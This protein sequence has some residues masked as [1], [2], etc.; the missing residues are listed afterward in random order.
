MFLLIR[1]LYI[2][3]SI[4]SSP[5]K[6]QRATILALVLC[7]VLI[8]YTALNFNFTGPAV[9]SDEIGYLTKAALMAGYVTD[10]A[11]SWQAGYSMFIFPAFALFNDPA[12][13]WRAVVFINSVL[14]VGSLGL[15]YFLLKGIFPDKSFWWIIASI[16]FCSIYPSW[17]IMAG[18][19]FGTPAFLFIFTLSSLVIAK[20]S[21]K[22]YALIALAGF[23]VGFL[24]WI[25]PIGLAVLMAAIISFIFR[26]KS[27]LVGYRSLVIFCIFAFTMV[28]FYY[29]ILHPT[30]SYLVVPEGY[31]NNQHYSEVGRD[32]NILD[33]KLWI[34]IIVT[35][36]SQLSYL[37]VSTF[38]IVMFAIV[39]MY[40]ETI[41]N[42]VKKKSKSN[43][44]PVYV[45]IVFSLVGVILMG[46]VMF[47]MTGENILRP[48]HRI[49]GRY[50]EMVLLPVMGIGLLSVWKLRYSFY[51]AGLLLLSGLA[52]SFYVTHSNTSDGINYVNIAAFWPYM[53]V[54][55]INYLYWFALGAVAVVAAALLGKKYFLFLVIPLFFVIAGD[56]FKYHSSLLNDPMQ[57]KKSP[58]VDFVR[59][60]IKNDCIG[61]DPDDLDVNMFKELRMRQY[62]YYLYDYSPQRM[63]F[64]NWLES[65]CGIYLTFDDSFVK[66]NKSYVIAK[67]QV[68]GLYLIVKNMPA[69]NYGY[70][71]ETK[72]FYLNLDNSI[73]EKCVVNG[74]F[75]RS[76]EELKD[77]LEVGQ[78]FNSIIQTSNQE[79]M[80][81]GG[82][83]TGLKA[84]KYNLTLEGE[85]S[86]LDGASLKVKDGDSG[87]VFAEKNL[88]KQSDNKLVIP[89]DVTEDVYRILIQVNVSKDSDMKIEYYNVEVR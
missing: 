70:D 30:L 37:I 88:Q 4:F 49:Y 31:V 2:K 58:M 53:I 17:M 68:T 83:Y 36:F 19:S 82:P 78:V 76:P 81:F 16:A 11:S 29:L 74:C 59:S 61:Y 84:D 66:D 3:N 13:I 5:T 7:S 6:V 67:D 60:N 26:I 48:D 40:S 44:A 57:S 1:K 33:Y 21:R 25:H 23:L 79:G 80:L 32:I 20:I 69:S 15:M 45:Y 73:G 14:L 63:N 8:V 51:S 86:N 28:A 10:S 65:E 41:K 77:F 50:S 38:G 35:F 56:Q 9:L 18:Y 64:D 55:K 75:D 85:F 12:Q 62:T 87:K 47:N 71:H 42:M 39:Y 34:K 72:E 54:S 43:I 27:G 89:F 52:L 24:A 22:N 46:S